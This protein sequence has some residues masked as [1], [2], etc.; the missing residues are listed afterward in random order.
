MIKGIGIDI[1]SVERIRDI[2]SK[3]EE[4]QLHRIFTKK[5]LGLGNVER[6]AGRFA[7][8][9]SLAKALGTGL[10]KEVW[11]DRIEIE[12][13][14]RGKPEFVLNS[15][16]TGLLRGGRAHLSIS[17]ENAYAVAMVVVE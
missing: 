3:Y 10:G 14:D 13:D 7:A 1:V 16:L 2:L 12:N 17:H 4:N 9:E 6:L 5:E 15:T 11:F 8:K